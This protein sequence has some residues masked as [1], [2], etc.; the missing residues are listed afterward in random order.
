MAKQQAFVL[1]GTGPSEPL[2]DALY[3]HRDTLKIEHDIK[4]AARS[5]AEMSYA[6]R[7]IRRD[8]ATHEFRRRVVEGAWS[9]VLRRARKKPRTVILGHPDLARFT[10]SQAALVLDGLASFQ[11]HIV[12]VGDPGDDDL[13]Y[14]RQTWGSLLNEDPVHVISDF[15][16]TNSPAKSWVALS[17]LVGFDAG[18]LPLTYDIA[19]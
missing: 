3:L 11:Q 17:Q 14:A 7:E 1:I 16:H 18:S 2:L 19:A 9:Q 13:N 12:L 4:V 6:I 10:R 8:H 5:A 15:G